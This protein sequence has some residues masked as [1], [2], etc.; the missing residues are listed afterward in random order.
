MGYEWIFI[1][2][3]P[4]FSP[5]RQKMLYAA[6][7][8]TLKKDFGGG[9]IKEELSGTVQ[10]DVSL[11]GYKKHLISR[12]APAP[13]TFAEE[14]LDLIKKTEVNTSVHVDSKHQT[15]KG[16][17]FPISDEA[18]QK[19]QDLR[20][21]HITYVQLSINLSEETVELEEASDIGV[22]VL[23]SRVPTDHA[24]YHIFTYKHTHEGDYTESII[25]IYSMPG[26]KCPIKERMLYSSCS[27]P[28][29][30]SIKEMGL[31]IA[32]KLEIDNPKELTEANIHEEIHPK[33][34]VARQAF[35]KPKGPA[36]RG[37]KRMTKAPGEED[38]NSN[39]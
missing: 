38:D 6:T 8:A 24:R 15:M 29:V 19:L 22:N 25:F 26:Y 12:N 17:Q 32:R 36:K 11:S 14:E 9:Q 33:K 1:Y 35:A 28:L 3:C 39:E 27:G 7:R 2:W 21:G 18:L 16:L 30:E 13:L 20:E 31:E 10:G 37:P 5:V 23:A 4:D 34:N